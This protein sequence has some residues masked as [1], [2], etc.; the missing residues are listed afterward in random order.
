MPLLVSLVA[1]ACL[2]ALVGLIR[3]WSEQDKANT[4]DLGGVRTYSLWAML[5]CLGAFASQHSSSPLPLVATVVLIAGQQLV[6]IA[7]M[8]GGRHPGG[9]TFASVLLTVFVGILVFWDQR[10]T[11]IVVAATTMVLLG[12][13][14]PIHTWTRAF[15]ASDLRATLQFAAITGVV[16]P[17]VPNRTFGPY[18]AFNP[19]STWLMVVLISGLGFAGYIAV[20]IVGAGAGIMLTSLFG[21]IASSTATTL[22]FSRRSTDDPQLSPN[23]A[24]AVVVACTVMLPRLLI[25]IGVVNPDLALALIV[26]FAVMALPGVAYAGWRWFKRAPAGEGFAAPA[27]HNPLNLRVALK[28]GVIYAAVTFLVKA[29]THFGFNTGVL[30][31]SFVS[32]LTDTDAISLS[33]AG[34]LGSG[35]VALSLAA[36]AVIVASIAN[37]LVKAAIAVSLGSPL[38]KRDSAIVLGLTS[39]AGAAAAWWLVP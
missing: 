37:S 29:F 18:D 4:P 27:L 33:M 21:G 13:K 20:R 7:K 25:V 12:L 14:Q 30:P 28:F 38:L 10:Q 31:L 3:Q 34:N 19:Y 22:T 9:T 39:V 2:G 15:T 17:L 5:G 36:R 24:L 23:F 11:A 16:L 26:P 1:S 35:T 6:S 8:P 32:G